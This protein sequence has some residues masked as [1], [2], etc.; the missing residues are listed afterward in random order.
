MFR[1]KPF[2]E[3]VKVT[4]ASYENIVTDLPSELTRD[5][6]EGEMRL[7]QIHSASSHVLIPGEDHMSYLLHSRAVADVIFRMVD[8]W[9]IASHSKL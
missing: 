5:W 1:L 7:R 8:Q 9:R 4:I 3:D 6:S 2:P